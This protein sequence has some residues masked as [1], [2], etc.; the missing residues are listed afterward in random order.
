LQQASRGVP[1]EAPIFVIGMPRTGTTLVER[2]LSSHPDVSSAGELEDLALCVKRATGTRSPRVFDVETAERSA[3]IDHAAVGRRYL[4]RTRRYRERTRRF[5]DK[6]P[7][8][9]FYVGLIHLALPE[10][11]IVCLRRDPMDTCL[12]NFR[13]LFGLNFS[14]YDYAYDLADIAEYY[15]L[16]DRLIRHWRQALPGKL[17]ELE[18][19]Q[20]VT[21]QER[22]TRR[23]LEFCGLPWDARCLRFEANEAAVATASAVQVRQTLHTDAIGRWR[24]Y[25]DLLEPAAARLRA[26]GY[27]VG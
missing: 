13:Q 2:I 1:G 21:A 12:S 9:F 26:A 17:L 16:F 5:V 15:L 14:Y 25:G 6:M 20:L 18:Y 3:A 22:Q 23:L 19:E 7:L 4:E 8:N 11:K 24:R 10:A 27:F